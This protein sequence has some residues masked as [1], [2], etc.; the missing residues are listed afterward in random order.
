[1]KFNKKYILAA[2]T[3]IAL[4]L[5][6]CTDK[7]ADINDSEH[8]FSDEDLTQDFNHV[9][10]L[11]EPMINN[12]YTYDPPW[13]TQL[14]QNLIGDVYSGFMMPP[15]PFAGNINNMT[16][17]LVD[18]WNGFPWSTAYS[19]IMTNALRV[20]QRTA[21]ETNSPFYAWSL[22]L[23][24]EAMHRVSDIYG[25]IVYSEF[26]TEEATIPY[27]SQKDVYY[28]FF[29]ELKT[30]VDILTTAVDAGDASVL[31]GTDFT[32]YAGDYASWVKFA[33]SLR[34]RLAIRI[35]KV[36]PSKAQTEAEAAVAHSLG[37]IE[38]NSGSAIAVSAKYMHPL[39]TI[40]SAW[41]DVRMGAP[42]ESI[43]T[44]Y[45]D[46]RL[47]VYFNTSDIDPGN[48]KGIRNGIDIAAKSDYV[49]FSPLGSV[50]ETNEVT[51]MPA[52]EVHFLRAE[53]ALRGW[54]MGGTAQG[55]Y[56]SG[57]AESFAQHGAG[58][59]TDYIANSSSTANAYVDPVNSANNV[60]VG[61]DYLSTATIAWDESA[62]D[63]IKLEKIITQK[64]IALF[65]DGQEAWSEFRRT[66]YPTL[67][68]VMVNNSGGA[69][70]TEDFIRRVNFVA[71]EYANN[72]SG[73]ATGVA[74][75]GGTD[76][77]G[78]RL[79]WDTGGSNF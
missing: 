13:V 63:E 38:A 76:D 8:G 60:D 52:A 3:S 50:I 69:I 15:T 33:N 51:W 30:A 4:I 11:Y 59:A 27:D 68:P 18:G 56:E 64:W 16:Y 48:Y 45:S 43:L 39:I 2:F 29:D 37:V 77:G 26:G 12:V 55:F 79:W 61:S 5:T 25:P 22:I 21:E 10:S 6:G 46:P 62:E 36:D 70:S 58:D 75:L 31:G 67:F 40:N 71:S 74:H 41:G 35:A 72:P 65:P 44:G 14:Q 34:L 20:Y 42:M 47:P 19:N 49:V 66:G 73:V 54:S 32:A 23:K 28:K 17:A 53:G 1:M 78:T 24:V 57:I 7:F 9:K